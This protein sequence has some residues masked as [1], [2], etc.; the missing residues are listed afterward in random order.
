MPDDPS[1]EDAAPAPSL[2]Q[3]SSGRRG[4]RKSA[5]RGILPIGFVLNGIYEVKRFIARGGMGEVYEGVNV[6]AEERVAVKVILPHLAADPKV[7]ALFRKEAKTLTSL[8]HPALVQYRVLAREPRKDL[9]YIVTDF[10]DGEPLTNLIGRNPPTIAELVMLTRRLA[11]GLHAAH[12]HGAIHRDIS[13]ENILLSDGVLSRAKIIDFGIAKSMEIGAH[14]VVGDGFA[15]KLGYVAPEQFGDFD[16]RIGPW[17]DVYSLGLVVLALAGG[18]APD[19]G[20]TLV[21]AIDRRRAGADLAAVPPLLQ[22]LFSRMLSPDPRGRPQTMAEVISALDALDVPFEPPS[23]LT[24]SPLPRG[25]PSQGAPLDL[26]RTV[27]HFGSEPPSWQSAEPRG[28]DSLLPSLAAIEPDTV[29]EIAPEARTVFA[30]S[31]PLPPSVDATTTDDAAA[32]TPVEPPIRPEP[33]APPTIPPV[34]DAPVA[35]RPSEDEEEEEE[36]NEPAATIFSPPPEVETPADVEPD[37]APIADRA[38]DIAPRSVFAAATTRPGNEAESAI[39]PAMDFAYKTGNDEAGDA[40]PIVRRRVGAKLMAGGV[41]AAVVVVGIGFAVLSSQKKARPPTLQPVASAPA[42]PNVVRAEQAITAALPNVP[43]AWLTVSRGQNADGS[44]NIKVSGTAGD[45]VA[46]N[47]TVAGAA[48]T[49]GASGL[50]V[51]TTEILQTDQA[52]CPLLDTVG[53]S[54]GPRDAAPSLLAQQARF[55]ID[56]G[57]QGCPT[58]LW[59]QSMI[60]VAPD[61]TRNFSLIAIQPNGR[62]QQFAGNREQF[63]ALAARN[64]YLYKDL[65]GGRYRVSMCQ[66]APGLAGVLMIEGAAPFDVGLRP[67]ALERPK[68][69]FPDRLRQVAQQ[70]GW[71]MQMAWF[72]VVN[73]QPDLPEQASTDEAA[74]HRR[75]LLAAEKAAAAQAAVAATPTVVDVPLAE[76]QKLPADHVACRRFVEGAWEELGYATRASCTERVFAGRC[77]VLSGQSGDIALRRYGDRLQAKT[78]RGFN[79]WAN[80]GKSDCAK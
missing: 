74:R 66:N 52:L 1:D 37:P 57:I 69:D 40:Q 53:K 78:G 49:A 2:T 45:P 14:T 10:I 8:A 79:K 6:N 63:A 55:E 43:C 25:A 35:A 75:E 46:A 80:V 50:Q 62:L 29:D 72:Q 73:D 64:P 36:I 13:P 19:M 65:G 20:T 71:T 7:Q 21:E 34:A 22:P 48:Q 18:K 11:E 51:D 24:W 17:T 33:V 31:V 47:R 67:G 60:N 27:I 4:S 68:R 70:K 59:A 12:S 16:R 9:L 26:E 44:A 56:R 76:P 54:A 58:G 61:P 39:P 28:Q 38:E 41:T 3:S 30:P 42:P 15:G 23:A 77:D 5:P 32:P